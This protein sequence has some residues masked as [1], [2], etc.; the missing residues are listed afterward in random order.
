MPIDKPTLILHTTYFPVA[1][2]EDEADDPERAG[3]VSLGN[4]LYDILTRRR[5][6]R[7][8]WGAG[9]NVRIGTRFDKVDLDEATHVIVVP[10]LGVYSQANQDVC[11]RAIATIRAWSATTRV[12]PVLTSASWRSHE[13]KDELAVKLLFD[14]VRDRILDEI[15]IGVARVLARDDAFATRLFISHAKGDLATTENAA[16]AIRDHVQTST[17]AERP[18][19]D[20][21]S[22]LAGEDLE[23][24]IDAGAGRGVFMA[25]RGDSYSSRSWC[26][27]EL[28]EAKR[29]RL[30]V[31]TVEV[32][33]RGEFRSSA[34]SGNGPTIV[35]SWGDP[36]TTA[37][38]VVRFAM[39]ECVRGLLFMRE[40]ARVEAAALPGEAVVE[41]PRAPELLDLP[42][43]RALSDR[44]VIVLHPDPELSIHERNLLREADRRIRTV[45][46]TSAFGG[47]IGRAIRAPL[48][49]WQ[50][51]ISLSDDPQLAASE[52]LVAAHIDD[53]TVSLA[54]VLI[55]AG[56]AIGY[57]GDFRTSGFTELLAQLVSAYSQTAGKSTEQLHCYLA[58]QVDKL[59]PVR[60]AFT[61]HH[62]GRFGSSQGSAM[63][64]PPAPGKLPAHRAALYFSDMRRVMAASTRARIVL[65][66]TMIPRGIRPDATPDSDLA[67]RPDAANDPRGYG[68]RY[69]GVIEE[70]WWTLRAKRPL[71]VIG[72][73]GGAARVLADLLADLIDGK[74]KRY[75]RELTEAS[76]ATNASWRELVAALE[77]DPDFARLGLPRT[78]EA[79]VDGI[80]EACAS[81]FVNDATALHW[82]GLSRAE[83]RQLLHSRD[84]LAIAALVLKGLVALA[85]HVAATKLRIE[86]VEG[87]VAAASDLDVLVFPTFSDL[88]PEGAGAALDRVSGNAATRAHAC[89]RPVP[90][91][92]KTLGTD[93][94]YAADL[95][96]MSVALKDPAASVSAAAAQTAEMAQ[97]Y[98]FAR[99]GLV[100]FLGNVAASVAEVVAAMVQGLWGID[101]QIIWYERDAARAAMLA[102]LLGATPN[103]E[104]TRRIQTEVAT[105]EPP[106]AKP[107]TIISIRQDRDEI[108]VTVLLPQANGLA[109]N[110]RSAFVAAQRE[111]LAGN[112]HAVAPLD[113]VLVQRGKTIADLMF[114][115]GAS[116]VL[117]AVG[118]SE[119]VILHDAIASAVPYE[120]M[121]WM[122]DAAR[123]TPAT[124]GGIV[125]HLVASV[126][127][128][129]GLPGPTR[130]GNMIVLVVID[131]RGDLP[132]AASEGERVAALLSKLPRLDLRVLRGPEAT[133]EKLLAALREVDV[134]HYCGHA[135]YHGPGATESGLCCANGDLTSTQLQTLTRVP[136]LAVFNACQAG[137]VR[138]DVE[139][140]S[141]QSFAEFF[142]RA[143]VEAYLGTF[144]LVSDDGANAFATELYTKLANGSELGDAVVQ[145]RRVLQ[146][147]GIS[148]WANYML[149]GRAGFRLAR[150]SD[151]AI[152]PPPPPAASWARA[153]GNAI[154]A[155]WSFPATGA[156][157]AFA[158]TA[159]ELVGAS[160]EPVRTEG[161]APIQI[162]RRD[163]WEGGVAIVKWIATVS[164]PEPVADRGF[165][166]R[167]SAG[168]PIRIGTPRAAP[169]TTRAPRTDLDE[170]RALRTVL[171]QQPDK[172][173]TILLELVPSADP[174]QLRSEID[175]A[176][177]PTRA[178]WPLQHLSA[179]AIDAAALAAFAAQNP[180]S[181]TDVKIAGDQSF[182]TKEDWFR[183]ATAKGVVPFLIGGDVNEPLSAKL[184]PNDLSYEVRDGDYK[185]GS[186]SL[187]LFSDNCNGRHAALAIAQQVVDAK[188]PYAFHL[189]D[190]YY[191]GTELEFAD[192]FDVPLSRM[193]DTTELFTIAGNHEMFA[194][195]EYFQK[196]L[197][198][199]LKKPRQ[200]QRA[201]TFRLCGK[202]FQII[203][204]D[205][206]FVGWNAGRMRVHDYAD[207]GQL[208]L[209]D[210]WLTERPDDLTILMTTNEPWTR[211]TRE[212]RPL[213]QSLRQTIA[214]R[215]DLWFW[216]NVHYGA[217][218]EP[219]A[220]ADAGVPTRKL[221]GSCIGHGGYPY[222]R[223][224]EVGELPAGVACRWL[225]TKSR[226][227]P[228]ESIRHDVGLNGWCRMQLTPGADR[229][230][231]GLTYLDWVGRER[232]R[233]DLVRERGK[234]IELASVK[235]S[236]LDSVTAPMTWSSI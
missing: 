51:G 199:K 29:R 42:R 136:R 92:L 160:E 102:R 172:G 146:R 150:A 66:G 31:V 145:A 225:E 23:A 143:G 64:A 205:T 175:Q 214:G 110:L 151:S 75:P 6:D 184:G 218:Y 14:E 4:D 2:P 183:Y 213:Y 134:V 118:D 142:L 153:E 155:C 12:L 105:P 79:L 18:F 33:K 210:T 161:D 41:M 181:T 191:G 166:L 40:A 109:P 74:P 162:D 54:R 230:R 11:A 20:S 104:L 128:N 10:V 80:W 185:D 188:L 91:A 159:T 28:L 32:L 85:A 9:V 62:L 100:T 56:A 107:Q 121:G 215:V 154:I 216:G 207:L 27:R 21:V 137:R 87:D 163:G 208:M 135:F 97:R 196:M 86:L 117:Q 187:A 141:T 144:W 148:D 88:D 124:S 228:D 229:W 132:G 60:Y 72:G 8:S 193:L 131:P 108:D 35:W 211:G 122:V 1:G 123:I 203:G 186:L 219:W 37:A 164:L 22:L 236:A 138:G 69:P 130:A 15:V 152:S 139:T 206:M 158:V 198:E 98:G 209:L 223:Q 133:V 71:Y 126:D 113:G 201:E 195:G 30:S 222:Y 57:G 212:L 44:T 101:A 38:K 173:R 17:T 96:P 59:E 217:L 169:P 127:A 112:L 36:K 170:L 82:N 167:A 81:H 176:L 48:D 116:D 190:V 52:G 7:L 111:K 50:V 182:Q 174:D 129:R 13:R 200:R 39:V 119:V 61:A 171:D 147:A 180:L 94:V 67:K 235:E 177:A 5:D 93:F 140:H 16:V 165:C 232:L 78:Q 227:W 65:S 231:V 125:R 26:L 84:P 24:Q 58:A 221:V 34:Y 76:W 120:A 233:V 43:L 220:F 114:G 106:R 226:F 202:G 189:G 224:D 179:P 157:S 25:I 63:L 194:R 192:Y 55:A 47:A 197:V 19:F 70:A 149:Y 99:I 53:A 73:F 77:A 3:A 234:S 83:N 178:V 45:T 49:G 90:P 204:L 46:P 115:L 156:P 95:G 68:G 103:V 89:R 168:P